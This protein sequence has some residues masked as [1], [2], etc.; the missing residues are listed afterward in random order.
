[1]ALAGALCATFL[2]ATGITNKSLRA[3]ITGLLATPLHPGQKY[4][5]RRPG[6]RPDPPDRAHQ[7]L[8]PH[9]DGTQIPVLFT[10]LHNRLLR[11]LLAAASLK[12]PALGQALRARG[13]HVDDYITAP[14]WESREKTCTNVQKLD[15]DSNSAETLPARLPGTVLPSASGLV[16]EGASRPRVTEGETLS[17]SSR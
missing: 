4:D 8:R 5:M 17:E 12:H 11:P 7:C 3:F 10:K 2:A 13:Q 6:S 15:A 1:M 9:P 14:A 16:T